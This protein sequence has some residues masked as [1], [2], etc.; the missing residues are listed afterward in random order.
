MTKGQ[1][2][3]GWL[4]IS[5]RQSDAGLAGPLPSGLFVIEFTL[6]LPDAALLCDVAIQDQGE[7]GFSIF[8]QPEAGLILRNRQGARLVRHV[9][10]GRLPDEPGTA[11]L[12]FAFDCA[13]DRWD[14]R[15]E[16]VGRP[17]LPAR[18]ARGVAPLPLVPA[19]IARMSEERRRQSRHP[20]VLW[21]GLA[22]GVAAPARIAWIGLRSPV[23]TPRGPVAA[24]RLQPGDLV[25]TE[26]DGALPLLSSL[27]MALP[28]C[29]SFAP[30]LLRAPFLPV[31][32]DLLLSA[33]QMVLMRGPEVEYLFGD[34]EVLVPGAALVD[35]RTALMEQRRMVVP[36]VALLF[37]RP[38]ILNVDGCGLLAALP[39]DRAPRLCLQE[40][41]AQM[42]MTQL[43]RGA[44]RRRA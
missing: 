40:Y 11:R 19:D 22:Q 9:L 1:Q 42:L 32:H 34:D 39:Q 28:A 13:A 38:A 30:V 23:E 25:L 8:Y 41:E 2:A 43:G 29:G 17:D 16:L 12:A 31:Q 20:A 14:L 10:P 37:D 7:R 36:S 6:P 35:G 33:D 24:G 15:L 4:V 26:D 44:A 21:F 27:R 18:T 3:D 5:D